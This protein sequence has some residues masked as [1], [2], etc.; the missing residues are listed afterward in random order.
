MR[1]LP[2]PRKNAEMRKVKA[3]SAS[4]GSDRVFSEV[5]ESATDRISAKQG[6]IKE[7]KGSFL[8]TDVYPG[9]H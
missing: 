4:L 3:T 8:I 2:S 9:H 5:S 7:P 1:A 6:A